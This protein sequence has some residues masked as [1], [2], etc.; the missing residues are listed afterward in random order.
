M[1]TSCRTSRFFL[2]SYEPMLIKHKP[3]HYLKMMHFDSASYTP[4]AAE[5]CFEDRSARTASCSA[6]IPP[7]IPL[8]M[9]AAQDDG[10][11]RHDAG[12][13]D[14]VMGGNAARL[15]KLRLKPTLRCPYSLF[16]GRRVR[17][18]PFS[19]PRNAGMERR[20]APGFARPLGSLRD[21]LGRSFAKGP[22]RAPRA[23]PAGLSPPGMRGPE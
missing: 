14:K 6:P 11:D 19:V 7:L 10:P 5:M 23:C 2:G 17:P 20:E 16:S 22:A 3:S 4:L 9:T 1:P 18:F 12:E 13:R 8:K 15:L 21:S